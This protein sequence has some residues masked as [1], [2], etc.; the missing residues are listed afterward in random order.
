MLSAADVEVARAEAGRLTARLGAAMA[1]LDAL[2]L[3]T[4]LG[5]APP[6]EAFREGPRWTPMRTIP[7]NLA[8]W[9]AISV[10]CGFLDGLPV[11][12]QLAGPER[13][14]GLIC[15]IAAAFERATDHAA[16]PAPLNAPFRR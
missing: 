6:F 13:S 5:P 9:P 4:T 2:L 11:G 3:P 8:G 12:M 10:P 15:A 7:F 16:H 1:G 14:E